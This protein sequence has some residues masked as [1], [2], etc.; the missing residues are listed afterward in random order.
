MAVH[1]RR[2]DD[3]ERVRWATQLARRMA[4]YWQASQSPEVPRGLDATLDAVRAANQPRS[5]VRYGDLPADVRQALWAGYRAVRDADPGSFPPEV[6]EAA[7]RFGRDYR[8]RTAGSGSWQALA[9][10]MHRYQANRASIAQTLPGGERAESVRL[11]RNYGLSPRVAEELSGLSPRTISEILAEAQ[12]R[13]G[14]RNRRAWATVVLRRAAE[15]G[16]NWRR[17]EDAA[18]STQAAP[19]PTSSGGPER[20]A[21]CGQFMGASH[22]C[23]HADVL[24]NAL[25]VTP[26]LEPIGA[27]WA[28]IVRA[29]ADLIPDAQRQAA[30]EQVVAALPR[31]DTL[32]QALASAPG[33]AGTP[34]GFEARW[35][36]RAREQ[37]PAVTMA[38]LYG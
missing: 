23:R 28:R 31:I 32:A 12:S 37:T 16:G 34:L 15:N 5:R 35:Y 29:P 6:V 18:P 20:C 9:D 8:H 38:Q 13:P 21:A 17:E 36:L 30:V 4:D 27:E 33:V 11:L 3:A 25:A 24:A 10:A 26:E 22:Q 1:D 7:Q 2:P 14:V 19:A